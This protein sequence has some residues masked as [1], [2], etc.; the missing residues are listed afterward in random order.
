VGNYDICSL[1]G[2]AAERSNQR[3]TI[4]LGPMFKKISGL[5]P[6]P[7]LLVEQ[8]SPIKKKSLSEMNLRGTKE[9]FK[10]TPNLL[11]ILTSRKLNARS[12][13]GKTSE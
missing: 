12:I 11:E 2:E 13:K 10:M 3:I 7:P 6:V 5:S 9:V 4:Q 1:I 8:L